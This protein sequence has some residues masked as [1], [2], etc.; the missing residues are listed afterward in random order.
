[1]PKTRIAYFSQNV[2]EMKGRS[3]LAEVIAGHSALDELNTK[4]RQYEEKISNPDIDPDE[5]NRILEEM[6]DVQTVIT[7][8]SIHYTK[9]Y[10]LPMN[11]R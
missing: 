7:S 4:L 11:S 3:A 5:M 9:L 10:E 1:M 6:G 2:G 8:Y